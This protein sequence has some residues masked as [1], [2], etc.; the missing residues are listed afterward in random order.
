MSCLARERVLSCPAPNRRGKRVLENHLG[1]NSIESSVLTESWSSAPSRPHKKSSRHKITDHAN[2]NM[3]QFYRCAAIVERSIQT[4]KYEQIL[5]EEKHA[6]E[7]RRKRRDRTP[8]Q[9]VDDEAVDEIPPP[10]RPKKK[11]RAGQRKCRR[12]W[13]YEL[14]FVTGCK[15]LMKWVRIHPKKQS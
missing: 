2:N 7:K 1:T 3:A 8:N 12:G 4:K 5:A 6:K 14:Q 15:K 9:F 11:P 13:V 10:P